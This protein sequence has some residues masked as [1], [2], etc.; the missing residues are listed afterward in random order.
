MGRFFKRGREQLR[1]DFDAE[2]HQPEER[3]S[4]L[5]DYGHTAIYAALEEASKNDGGTFELP[6]TSW[7]WPANPMTSDQIAALSASYRAREKLDAE[8]IAAKPAGD[9]LKSH[10]PEIE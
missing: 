10:L 4:S 5:S 8:L 3:R 2:P 7:R 9:R 1:G 6:L